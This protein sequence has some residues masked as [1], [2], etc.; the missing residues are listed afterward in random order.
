MSLIN[1]MLQD[2]DARRADVPGQGAYIQQVRAVPERRRISPAWWGVAGLAVAVSA[3]AAWLWLRHPGPT[4]PGKSP[5]KLDAD[6]KVAQ[7]VAQ[8]QAPV[9]PPVAVASTPPIQTAEPP[10]GK[11]AP[12]VAEKAAESA[13]VADA[14]NATKRSTPSAKPPEHAAKALAKATPVNAAPV[15]VPAS[16]SVASPAVNIEKPAKEFT[17][18]QLAENAYRKSMLALQQGRT[19]EAA[20]GLEQ[21]LRLDARHAAARQALIRELASAGRQD[22]AIRLAREGLGMDPNQPAMAMALARLQL[23]KGELRSAV[24]TMEHTLPYGADRADYV[25]FLAGL[26]QRDGRHK[27]AA[28]QYVSALQRAPQNGVW[29][30]GLG[31]SLQADNRPAE[32]VEAF[33]RAK[34]ANTLSPDLLAFVDARLNQLKP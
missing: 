12:V 27:Q 24:D 32:A 14:G 6:L 31:I 28:E 19:S 8:P 25:A 23:D 33:K 1:K 4:Q 11:P 34:A 30:M 3:S 22:D 29:W 17:P 18:Q 5:L 21:V 7:A 13:Q 16:E 15:S 2:L 20:D 10:A 9:A 26:L